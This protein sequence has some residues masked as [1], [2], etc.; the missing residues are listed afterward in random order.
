MTQ[1]VQG[2]AAVID[3]DQFHIDLDWLATL[4]SHV[5][6]DLGL[7]NC[8]KDHQRG[9]WHLLAG[10]VLVETPSAETICDG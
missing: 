6:P 5:D 1:V 10:F 2:V 3:A 8:L 9:A 4:L 7:S